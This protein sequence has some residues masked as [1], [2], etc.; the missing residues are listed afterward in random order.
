VP[1]AR[2]SSA[3][4]WPALTYVN[5]GHPPALLIR[6]GGTAD[7]L[8]VGGPG[9]G[10]FEAG[11][12]ETGTATFGAGDTLLIY[13]DGV[14]ESWPTHEAA[15]EALVD[16]ARSYSAIPV[17]PLCEEILAVVDRRRGALRS[18]DCTLIVLRWSPAR[19]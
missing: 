3:G 13:S 6:A 11:D 18:D 1:P 14:S 19:R 15:E 7:R 5:A 16:M 2:M 4:G 17:A 12:F 8:G 9:V 10:L